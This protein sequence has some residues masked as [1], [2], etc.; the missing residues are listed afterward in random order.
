MVPVQCY[1]GG[2]SDCKAPSTRL[3]QMEKYMFVQFM[4]TL[5]KVST[6][7][8]ALKLTNYQITMTNDIPNYEVS[9][10]AS[11]RDS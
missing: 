1:A 6:C 5:I 9:K 7:N 11:E 4:L 8:P 10:A 2:I 3:P